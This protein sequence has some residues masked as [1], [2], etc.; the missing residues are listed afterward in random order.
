MSKDYEFDFD[1][2]LSSEEHNENAMGQGFDPLPE[3]QYD[4]YCQQARWK[5]SQK[6]PGN[7]YL[8]LEWSVVGDD[9]FNDRRV[10]QMLH[11]IN[12]N[13]KAKKAAQASVRQIMDSSGWEEKRAP[14][15]PEFPGMVVRAHVV[16][17]DKIVGGKNDG[18]FRNEI[19]EFIVGAT[20]VAPAAKERPATPE[21]NSDAPW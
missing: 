19:K 11:L 14:R 5:D 18:Q 9:E 8:S 20:S 1:E 10:F 13:D 2:S 21:K 16:L 4:L 17:G 7:S 15:G 6:K 12:T 3:G